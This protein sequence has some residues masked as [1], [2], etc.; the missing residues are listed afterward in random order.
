ME[1]QTLLQLIGAIW[2]ELSALLGDKWPDFE[3]A[4][5]G[6]LERLETEPDQALFV[7]VWILDLFSQHP[8][9]HGRLLAEIEQQGL[10]SY[11]PT[12][13][14]YTIKSPLP[15]VLTRLLQEE[16]ASSTVIRYTDISCPR[17]AW[18]ESPRISVV[19]RLAARRPAYSADAREL[20]LQEDLPVRVRIRAPGFEPLNEPEQ[21]TAILPGADS[22]AL[23]FDLRPRQ[24]G[25]THV[26][27]DFFQ[28]G[29][30]AGTA[31]VP[32]EIVERQVAETPAAHAAQRLSVDVGLA[33]PELMLYITYEHFQKPALVF[34][35]RRRGQVG[36]TFSPLA[37]EG[38]PRAQAER[39]YER[40]TVLTRQED[41]T[42][43]AVLGERRLLPAEDVDRQLK[44]FGQNLWR[45][46]IPK[47]LKD[48]YAAE[49]A[50]WRD[51]SL[52]I[53]SDE[54]YIPWE[55]VWPYDDLAGEWEDAEPWCLS[56]RLARWLRRDEQ[57]N[58]HEAP[59][60]PLQLSALACL[61]PTDS[62]LKA[63]Q[64]EQSILA[65]LVDQYQLADCSP[66][67]P[68]WPAVMDLLEGGDYDWL[69]VAAHGNFYAASPGTDS[70]I[71][72]QGKRPLTPEA[73]VGPAIE[74]HIRQQRPAFVFNACYTGRQGYGLTRLAGWANRLIST[75][76]GLFLAPLWT[77]RDVSALA[78]ARSFYRSF[79][80]GETLGESVR[81]GRRAARAE[82]DP[83]W[84]AYSVYGHPN[85][86]V[87]W[88]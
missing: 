60:A 56:T 77:V 62:G 9:A 70:A 86:R 76:A 78:F 6:Y 23:V 68:T 55:L 13:R 43:Q 54:P 16:A 20:A 63:A 69:H 64:A 39:L 32:V 36:R 26:S 18:I 25:P 19:V 12:T 46:L 48:V 40:L 22:P 34:E 2:A 27:L 3:E 5:Q 49:R 37:L 41:P 29:N 52:L 38:D 11:S 74:R 4:L 72:L 51:K 21:T 82:G 87:A 44:Q 53:V 67:S 24:V 65:G 59:P 81:Q 83:T 14:S 17:R 33:P 15:A 7:Q 45:A 31:S 88:E 1:I 57:G 47:E 75:G 30:P 73:I 80:G 10:E 8:P 84:L 85:A 71:W 35:L 28:G 61:A 50:D 42:G 58:G 79:L 66:A